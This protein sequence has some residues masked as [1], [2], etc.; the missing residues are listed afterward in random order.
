MR[1]NLQ[2]RFLI[3]TCVSVL[4]A[5]SAYLGVTTHRSRAALEASVH[6]EMQQLDKVVVEQTG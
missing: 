5:F 3:P 4:V 6:D 1:L 2:N